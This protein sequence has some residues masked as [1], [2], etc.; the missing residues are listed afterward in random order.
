MLTAAE[1]RN[2]W[3]YDPETGDLMWNVTTGHQTK[4]SM[5]GTETTRSYIAVQYKRIIYRKSR[6]VWLIVTGSWPE[7]EIDHINGNRADDRFSNLR[8]CSRSQNQCNRSMHKTNK[9]G[10]KGVHKF[11]NNYRAQIKHLG[12]RFDL[13]MFNTIQAAKDAYD[14]AAARLHGE[15]VRA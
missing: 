7:E 9:L 5:A 13:G 15:F 8:E 11:G 4:G 14:E 3:D 2:L 6:L 1:A 12:V 10:I